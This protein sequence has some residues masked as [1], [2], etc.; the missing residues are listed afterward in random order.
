MEETKE[1]A[2]VSRLRRSDKE[3]EKLIDDLK[4]KIVNFEY[5]RLEYLNDRSKLAKLYDLGLIDSVGD[6][7]PANP[8]DDQNEMK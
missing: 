1:T 7:L 4:E 8:D 5:E 3:K 6:P 2:E